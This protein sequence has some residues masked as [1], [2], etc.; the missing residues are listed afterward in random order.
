MK[1]RLPKFDFSKALPHW[2]PSLEFSQIYNAG[3]TVPAHIEPYLVKVMVKAKPLLP[4]ERA[5][6][7]SDLDIFIKQEMQHCKMHLAFNKR[8]REEGYA[9]MAG[10]EKEYAAD[11]DD[12]LKTKSLRFNLAYCEGFEAMSAIAVTAFFE[13][14]DE[15]LEGAD[16]E[17]SD[18]W[19]WHLAEEYEHR[20]VAHDVYH[21]LSGMNP[22][23]TYIY[24]VYG[25]LYAVHHIRK[26]T[27]KVSALLLK[28]DRAGM[29]AEE[30]EQSKRREAAV[31]AALG[32]S[33]KRHLLVILSPFY[34]PSKRSTPKGLN[35]YL[36]ALTRPTAIA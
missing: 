33:A 31:K 3:S 11:Y 29:S 19:K 35:R 13:D 6:L 12:F 21:A 17:V 30:I 5:D 15:F 28:K 27:N 25:F 32:R 10:L 14:F 36:D 18:L 9:E 23:F 26:H 24:R 4:P 16:P 2:S 22:L 20:S 7:Q 1:V 8:L 34:N